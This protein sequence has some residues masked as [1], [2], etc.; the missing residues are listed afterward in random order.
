L[1]A[2]DIVNLLQFSVYPISLPIIPAYTTSP[3]CL[4]LGITA[5]KLI[6][7]GLMVDSATVVRGRVSLIIG[8]GIGIVD[9]EGAKFASGFLQREN[10]RLRNGVA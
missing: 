6:A 8:L 10:R 2:S 7:V 3:L 5:D 1:S 4:W 9:V